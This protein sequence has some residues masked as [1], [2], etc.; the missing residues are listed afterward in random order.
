MSRARA[1]RMIY[2][3]RKRCETIIDTFFLKLTVSRSVSQTDMHIYAYRLQK[4][5]R[6]AFAGLL[7]MLPEAI[8]YSL[9]TTESMEKYSIKILKR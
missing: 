8:H 9:D 4:V 2:W 7:R 1:G 5:S 3:D 6:L